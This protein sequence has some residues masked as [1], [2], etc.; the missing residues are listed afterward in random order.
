M[1]ATFFFLK[2]PANKWQSSD[3]SFAG[4]IETSEVTRVDDKGN[5]QSTVLTASELVLRWY[6]SAALTAWLR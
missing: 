3:R 4:F 6:F 2:H 5:F 1:E